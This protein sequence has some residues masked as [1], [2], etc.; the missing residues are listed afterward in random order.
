MLL[1]LTQLQRHWLR[2]MKSLTKRAN[3]LNGTR[4]FALSILARLPSGWTAQVALSKGEMTNDP[5]AA[6]EY[7]NHA[8][9][10]NPT[11]W[12]GHRQRVAALERLGESGR[13][14][15]ARLLATLLMSRASLERMVAYWFP[16]VVLTGKRRSSV[17]GHRR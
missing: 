17:F 4:K 13:A 12:Q 8:I 16:E 3:D 5:H 7:A 15:Q 10:M 11:V 14:R 2:Q 1:D 6:L 9:H